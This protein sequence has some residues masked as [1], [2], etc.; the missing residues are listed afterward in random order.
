MSRRMALLKSTE[1]GLLLIEQVEVA[2]HGGQGTISDGGL[3][4]DGGGPASRS[5]GRG[6]GGK[7]ERA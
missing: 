2:L 4:E 5:A 1:G 6:G 3:E 7:Y